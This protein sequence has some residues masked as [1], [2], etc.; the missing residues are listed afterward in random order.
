MKFFST[1]HQLIKS[2]YNANKLGWQK[3]FLENF[4]QDEHGQALPWMC[5]P[6]IEFIQS[7]LNKNH[8]IFEF[9]SGSSTLFFAKKVKKVTSLESNEK[10]REI[11]LLK[12]KEQNS[13]NAQIILMPDALIN[14]L[15]ENYPK[16]CG[17]KFDFI[18]V[19]SL[20]RCQCVKNSIESLKPTGAIILDDSERANYKKI[21]DFLR[22][23]NFKEENFV[24]I[25]PAQF[26][27]KKTT[28]F[29]R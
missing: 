23:Q 17:Q 2:Q 1:S 21:F 9:G 27:L 24:G 28:I 7:R 13:S 26:R 4:S 25:A 22:E 8:E 12:L 16:N 29:W 6:F 11:M 19:D 10:W 15:Y 3:S 20:K 14:N 5:Y 18:I